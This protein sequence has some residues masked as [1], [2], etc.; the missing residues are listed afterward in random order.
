MP[1]LI[2]TIVIIIVAAFILIPQALFTVDETQLAIVTRFGEF[3]R[4][5]RS[6]GLYVK[7]PFVETVRKM[8][9]RLLRVDAQPASLL[10]SDKRNLVIDAYARYRIVD[11]L[12]FFQRLQTEGEAVSRVS[13]IVNSQLRREVALDTQSEVIS[14]TREQV[15]RRVANASNRSEISRD[16]A[17][18]LFNNNIRDPRLTIIV[19]EISD[20]GIATRG[21]P[22]TNEEL[23]AL[24]REARPEMLGNAT[25]AYFQ[26]L[27]DELGIEIVDVRIKR[28][29]FPTEIE[30]SVFARMRAE[31]ARIAEGL[32]AEGTQ[33]DREIRAEVDRDVQIIL[34]SAN[35]TAAQLRGEAEE[36]AIKI[37]AEALE[38]APEFYEFRRSLETYEKVLDDKALI[39]LE[40]DSDLFKYLQQPQVAE[41]GGE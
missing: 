6:P 24:S 7:Q 12:K 10:T 21:R 18:N 25:V 14:E 1:R 16:N 41:D 36:E 37:L 26:P 39:V 32:R 8:D 17:M 19:T 38:L 4:D 3:Q 35:G 9:S 33:R 13:D 29:D 40:S 5:Y 28:A 15:M 22:P 20:E 30:Q 27:V 23:D 34:E 2:I 11:P 31:R